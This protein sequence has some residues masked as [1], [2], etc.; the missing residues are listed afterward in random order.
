MRRFDR[1][2]ADGR[3]GA[4]A[5]KWLWRALTF[6]ALALVALCVMAWVWVEAD[7]DGRIC[8]SIADLDPAPAAI[9]FGTS[10][11]LREQVDNPYFDNRIAAAAQL[12]ASG[13]VKFLVVSGER[14]YGYDEPSDMRQ[15]LMAAGVPAVKI[16]R[17][18]A[19]FRT[20]DTVLRAKEVFDLDRAILV[21]QRFHLARALFLA[22]HHGLAYEGF[23]A[24]DVSLRAGLQT[25]VR[26][27]FARVAAVWDLAM[28]TPPREFSKPVQLGVDAPT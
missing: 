13:K 9:V 25:R 4:A 26:E 1:R 14:S 27:N 6:P 8:A 20:L 21:S 12:Y 3:N 15:A 18:Y 5:V 19:G 23:V 10:R 28:D 17:D 2:R 11:H 22:A 7:A 24:R 16:Y